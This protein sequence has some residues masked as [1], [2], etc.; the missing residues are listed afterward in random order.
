[1]IYF[2]D[3]HEFNEAARQQSLADKCFLIKNYCN[4]WKTY[5]IF[6]FSNIV[7]MFGNDNIFIEKGINSSE[8]E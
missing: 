5:K 3:E 1:M 4:N 7:D 2:S 6:S 8:R